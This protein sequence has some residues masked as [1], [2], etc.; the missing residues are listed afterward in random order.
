[1]EPKSSTKVLG[2]PA[3]TTVAP[4]AKRL[5]PPSRSSDFFWLP[6]SIAQRP[7]GATTCRVPA[8]SGRANDRSRSKF[9]VAEQH[10]ARC[11]PQA[12]C[13]FRDTR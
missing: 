4:S 13:H 11:S 8:G 12:L 5:I 2:L 6:L 7:V 10:Q 9:E 1:M 3:P